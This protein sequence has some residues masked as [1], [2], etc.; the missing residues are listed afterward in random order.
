MRAERAQ[1]LGS[2]G[3]LLGGALAF[4]SATPSG[5]QPAR[6]PYR[7]GVLN[8]AFG[9]VSPSVAGLL[10][11]L[12]AQG[13]QEGRDLT[14]D[15]R[16][17][18]GSMEAIRPA[19]AE[20]VKAGVDLIVAGREAAA[21]AA[22]SAT[23]TVPVVFIN[24]GDPVAAG[25]VAAM[26]RPGGN[27]TGI[28]NLVTELVPKRLEILKAVFPE[29]RRVWAVHHA[30]DL[31]ATAAIGRARAAAERLKLEVSARPVRTAE[32]LV[33]ALR[34][35]QAG[36]ALMPPPGFALNIQGLILDLHL[37]T[38]VPVVFEMDFWVKAGAVVSYGPSEHAAGF[39]AARLVAKI[40][41]GA[42]PQDVPVEAVDKV[43][44]ALN[45]P[46]AKKLGV[47]I[48]PEIFARADQIIE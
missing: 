26:A 37:Q 46:T 41:R 18:R 25:L 14:L 12:E 21:R 10:A 7:I 29:V 2:L 4:L 43:E 48:P 24:V 13:L 15:V 33:G 16:P 47:R 17:S 19:A 9:R 44:L 35:L 6:T 38:G 20:L 5:A 39:Q 45:L 31:S 30:D 11:G 22:Q 23:R 42:R 8:E 34:G 28:S 1:R 36:D 27:V 40:L 32:E 3:L